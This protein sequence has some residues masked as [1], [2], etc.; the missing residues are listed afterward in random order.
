MATP[1]LRLPGNVP[2]RF[3]ITSECID[4]DLCREAAPGVYRRHDAVGFTVVHHQPTS[5]AEEAAAMEGLEGC[6]AEAIG[7]EAVPTG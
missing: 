7:C 4:C 3:Y 2:G 5:P 1:S 6:P